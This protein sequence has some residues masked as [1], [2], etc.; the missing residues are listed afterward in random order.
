MLRK[1][2]LIK[3]F[4]E[5]A[6]KNAQYSKHHLWQY[7]NHPT[8]LYSEKVINQKIDYIHN[9]LV[10]TGLVSESIYYKYSSACF[11]SP[12]KVVN[13]QL[14]Q[15]VSLRFTTVS[16]MFYHSFSVVTCHYMLPLNSLN[17]PKFF[18]INSFKFLYFI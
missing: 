8:L 9:N 17:L 12:L 16:R 10:R 13:L 3:L 14:C 15:R 5:A 6:K 18:L 1:E 2:W 11:D 7:T 4:K